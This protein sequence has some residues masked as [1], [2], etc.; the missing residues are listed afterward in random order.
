[1]STDPFCTVSGNMNTHS[2][3]HVVCD[4]TLHASPASLVKK[5]NLKFCWCRWSVQ[6]DTQCQRI[7]YISSPQN[8][9]NSILQ[10]YMQKSTTG[11]F[12]IS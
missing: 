2:L 9:C 8:Y 5:E 12:R 1:M 10:N 7:R 6:V 3:L 11:M 4:A